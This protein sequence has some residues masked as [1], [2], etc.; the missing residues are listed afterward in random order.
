M[1]VPMQRNDATNEVAQEICDSE[2]VD[3]MSHPVN[4]EAWHAL[5]HFDAEFARDPRSVHLDLSMDGFQ[6]Y[7]SDSTAYSC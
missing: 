6:S 5:D 1:V 2:D 3:I 7:S 4:A